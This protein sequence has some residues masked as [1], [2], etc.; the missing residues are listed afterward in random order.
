MH[1]ES[2]S[3]ITTTRC[4]R[5]KEETFILLR[6]Q[7]HSDLTAEFGTVANKVVAVVLAHLVVDLVNIG[8]GCDV[9]NVE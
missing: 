1:T 3:K 8:H 5:L 6:A 4:R 2:L 9:R 7:L